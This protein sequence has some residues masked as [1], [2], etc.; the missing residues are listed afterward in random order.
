MSLDNCELF[1][2]RKGDS[3]QVLMDKDVKS[4]P[5]IP[6]HRDHSLLQCTHY[7]KGPTGVR[8]I[9]PHC[10]PGFAVDINTRSATLGGELVMCGVK[11]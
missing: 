6:L 5:L 9:S 11:L 10:S 1:K 7:E 2:M 8:Q 4:W 3:A